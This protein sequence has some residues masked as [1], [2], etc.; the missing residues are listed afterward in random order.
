MIG[1]DQVAVCEG[2]ILDKPGDAAT[3]RAQLCRQSNRSVLFY[4]AV[5]VVCAE[6][7]YSDRFV[8]LT[9]VRF[10]ELGALEIGAYIEAD[11]PYD[12]A[13]SLRSESLG[14][15][16]CER[17]ES[18]RP[19]RAHRAAAHPARREP[20]VLRLRFALRGAS[21][22]EAESASSTWA[23]SAGSGALTES[24]PPAGQSRE[25]LWACRNMRRRPRARSASLAVASPYF[26]SPATGW[27][28]CAACTRIWWVRPVSSVASSSEAREPKC[29]TSRKCVRALLPSG[30]HSHRALTAGARVGQQ[31]HVDELAAE[32]PASDDEHQVTLVHQAFAQ[33]FVQRAQGRRS[34]CHEQ[35]AARVAIETMRELE[36]LLWS[37]RAQRLD[38]AETEPAAA[39]HREPGRLVEREHALVLMDDGRTDAR[40][41]FR[42][43]ARRCTGGALLGARRTLVDRG[44][45]EAVTRREALLRARAPAIDAHFALADQPEDPGARDGREQARQ[46]L[47]EALAG[48]LVPHLEL[49]DGATRSVPGP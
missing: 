21:R 37:R 49:P 4:S 12:C 34:A 24:C 29:C 36:G 42:R 20:P 10:R 8:D 3:A 39:V 9:T 11:R 19:D 17:I 47:V 35:D 33:Q 40:D 45:T 16:L 18:R 48:L 2:V 5:A 30:A 38:D 32:L 43:H 26:S 6:R 25:M 13:G 31:R 7:G 46:G 27:P 23:S 14:L 44:Y 28:Q 1:A 15:S 41:E 22:P